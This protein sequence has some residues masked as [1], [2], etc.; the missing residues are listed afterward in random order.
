[1]SLSCNA[2]V[3][4]T[5]ESKPRTTRTKRTKRNKRAKRMR[6]SWELFTG[7]AMTMSANHMAWGSLSAT[8][9]QKSFVSMWSNPQFQNMT[10]M[11]TLSICAGLSVLDLCNAKVRLEK[12]QTNST[13]HSGKLAEGPWSSKPL[14]SRTGYLDTY[15]FKGG[16]FFRPLIFMI[17]Q[18]ESNSNYTFTV[19]Q[20]C[21]RHVHWKSSKGYSRQHMT[22]KMHSKQ[23]AK[24][25]KIYVLVW[26]SHVCTCAI[27]HAPGVK[28]DQPPL[29][30]LPNA[31]VQSVKTT[32]QHL[33][34][35]PIL[36]NRKI[37][38]V[39]VQ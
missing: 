1:M 37:S 30:H 15:W 20:G 19:I 22:Y 7:N 39:F 10:R 34:Q 24:A 14:P 6:R 33:L 2:V 26:I 21:F 4:T 35:V 28:T 31:K 36:I 11:E 25:S 9:T 12:S 29:M 16:G 38:E 17:F 5:R 27:P 18:V 32:E 23:I 3:I 8:T 13:G